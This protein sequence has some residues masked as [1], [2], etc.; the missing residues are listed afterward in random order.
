[1]SRRTHLTI[2][3]PEPCH[4]PW[5]EMRR[6]DEFRRHCNSCAKIVTD[7]TAMSEDEIVSYFQQHA[8]QKP[9]GQFTQEQLNRP[10]KLLPEKT[11]KAAWWKAAVLLPLSLWSKHA[12]AQQHT[13]AQDTSTQQAAHAF[14]NPHTNDSISSA[15]VANNVKC[16][17]PD[18]VNSP[19]INTQVWVNID[20]LTLV[21]PFSPHIIVTGGVPMIMYDQPLRWDIS[22]LSYTITML[23]TPVYDS[24]VRAR[25][26]VYEALKVKLWGKTTAGNSPLPSPKLPEPHTG[27][28]ITAT[29]PPRRVRVPKA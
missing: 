17:L 24:V 5:Q 10:M 1:M 16:A 28:G 12:F 3:I 29:E 2:S 21:N 26:S 4:V 14:G 9:C 7:F 25:D 27:E 19:Y 11:Q 13:N 20:S 18:T 15:P 8:A 23:Y 22:A 6:V